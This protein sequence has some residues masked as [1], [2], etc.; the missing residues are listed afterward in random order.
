MET[1]NS[2][3]QDQ[4]DARTNR[5]RYDKNLV[6]DGVIEICGHY[7]GP[8]RRQGTRYVWRC[9]ECGKAEKFSATTRKQICGCLNAECRMPQTMDAIQTIGFFENLPS[10]GPGFIRILKRGYEILGLQHPTSGNASGN[11]SG[12]TSRPNRS[13]ST[14]KS[15]GHKAAESDSPYGPAGRGNQP[16]PSEAPSATP[17]GWTM[18]PAAARNGRAGAEGPGVLETDSGPKDIWYQNTRNDGHHDDEPEITVDDG[19]PVD[20]TGITDDDDEIIEGVVVEEGDEE[21][22]ARDT[23]RGSGQNSA[24]NLRYERL[25]AHRSHEMGAMGE[26]LHGEADAWAIYEEPDFTLDPVLADAVYG[27][28]L[29]MCPLE[30]H[31]AKYLKDRG[32]ARM[33]ALRGRIGSMTHKLAREV[34]KELLSRFS[35]RDLLRVPGFSKKPL[36]GISFTLSGDYILIPYHDAD[37]NITT[38]EGRVVGNPKPGMGK[39]VSLRG[40]GNH[41]YVFPDFMPDR[42]EAFCEGA[43]GAIVAAQAGIA[44]GAI[45]GVRRHR[46]SNSDGPLAELVGTDFGRRRIPYIPDIDVKPAAKADVA[47]ETPK[48]C[49]N[50]IT[51]QNGIPQVALLPKG[52]DLD[53]WLL[54][55]TTGERRPAFTSFVSGAV[56]LERYIGL[57]GK[58]ASKNEQPPIPEDLP[59]SPGSPG[60]EDGPE[61]VSG[62]TTEKQEHGS[63]RQNSGRRTHVPPAKPGP[64]YEPPDEESGTRPEPRPEPGAV[65]TTQSNPD[66]GNPREQDRS[67]KPDMEL[68]GEASKIYAAIIRWAFIEQ[69][70]IDLMRR[71][72]IPEQVV[73]DAG[74]GSLSIVRAQ[75][76]TEKLLLRIGKEALLELDGFSAT[77]SG[78]VSLDFSGDYCLIPYRDATGSITAIHT[79]PVADDEEGPNVDR[80]RKTIIRGLPGDHLYVPAGEPEKI[81]VITTSVLEALRLVASGI[82]AAAIRK[83]G[84]YKPQPGKEVMDELE[85][86]DFVGRKILYSPVFSDSNKELVK[87]DSVNALRVLIGRQCGLPAI[88][89]EM[90]DGIPLGQWI[91]AAPTWERRERFEAQLEK[92]EVADGLMLSKAEANTEGQDTKPPGETA[93]EDSEG[94]LDDTKVLEMAKE[95]IIVPA[96]DFVTPSPPIKKFLTQDEVLSGISMLFMGGL[97]ILGVL[98][99]VHLPGELL[100]S[101][102]LLIGEPVPG[103]EIDPIPFAIALLESSFDAIVAAIYHSL[104]A[105]IFWGSA[106]GC[107]LMPVAIWRRRLRRMRVLKMLRLAR[108]PRWPFL[109]RIASKLSR[110]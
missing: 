29:D 105:A 97:L 83:V 87:Q 27:V 76:I 12:T 28:I 38:I 70:D 18:A 22:P 89:T 13:R 8:G 66:L 19:T 90:P 2:R 47:T 10:S 102:R 79:I 80:D 69:R 85:G 5:E 71:L 107:V 77:P 26:A 82:R 72:G 54:T 56:P 9:P 45:Q 3:N 51:N 11:A 41:L 17:S 101:M 53:E 30:E 21:D 65:T 91:L 16:A 15:T 23:G 78:G 94:S 33:T 20:H 84:A 86:V 39:Y 32:V 48:A 6:N 60:T 99:L 35:E 75:A 104:P 7:L 62:K 14:S 59:E 98:S 67:T 96:R 55:K 1:Y 74:L 40:S 42:L 68:P 95:P 106:L 61:A 108:P 31:H 103:R 58:D 36:R 100:S 88:L 109:A 64:L 49:R 57:S 46:D 50:L 52:K 63:P 92:A 110:G 4:N 93:D 43:M 81:E 34:K 25:D 73:R 37:H 24:P 44:I